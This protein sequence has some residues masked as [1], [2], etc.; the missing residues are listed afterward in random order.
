MPTTNETH[1]RVRSE[2]R[3]L[4]A[5]QAELARQ[6]EKWGQQ[7][8]MDGTG[9]ATAPLVRLLEGS[10]TA[11]SPSAVRLQQLAKAA[12]DREVER[13]TVTWAGVLIEELLEAL[14]EPEGSAEL[15]AELIQVAAVAVNWVVCLDRNVG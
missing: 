8:H 12:N 1:S 3:V 2:D 9:P 11:Y 13:G 14:A 7:D 10:T 15:R 6:Y 4:D 5:V